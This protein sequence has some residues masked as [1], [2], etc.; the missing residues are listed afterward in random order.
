MSGELLCHSSLNTWCQCNVGL[1]FALPVTASTGWRE[2]VGRHQG[3]QVMSGFH[4]KG[5]E[6]SMTIRITLVLFPPVERKNTK[7]LPVYSHS[8]GWKS[9]NGRASTYEITKSRTL[10]RAVTTN[11]LGFAIKRLS[12]PVPLLASVGDQPVPCEAQPYQ[13]IPTLSSHPQHSFVLLVFGLWWHLLGR[14]KL[15]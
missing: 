3:R 11:F 12:V 13:G 14:A 4:P 15:N 10:R 5:P 8:A 9:K 1:H 7:N 2:Q 6:S